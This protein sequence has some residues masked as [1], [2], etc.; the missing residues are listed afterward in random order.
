ME[1]SALYIELFRSL[2]IL[3]CDVLYNIILCGIV[4]SG[5]IML[6]KSIKFKN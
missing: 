5:I 2:T 6:I 3:A 4:G 1:V